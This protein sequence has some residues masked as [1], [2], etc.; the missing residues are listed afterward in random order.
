MFWKFRGKPTAFR[1]WKD[2]ELGKP[3]PP[4][5]PLTCSYI[6]PP[7]APNLVLG[8][9]ICDLRGLSCPPSRISSDGGIVLPP[10]PLSLMFRVTKEQRVQRRP[11]PCSKC[12]RGGLPIHHNPNHPRFGGHHLTR[13]NCKTP[14]TIPLFAQIARQKVSP[15]SQP[16]RDTTPL[17]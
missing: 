3:H 13:S 8:H 12:E 17:S 16:S 2:G 15:P 9:Q 7:P 4:N 6:E 11:L 5:P 1:G 14:T 10:Q